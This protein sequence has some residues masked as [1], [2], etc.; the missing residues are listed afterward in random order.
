[1]AC[2]GFACSKYSLAI[3]NV[4]YLIV[5]IVLI[6]LA[7]YAKAVAI[8][9]SVPIV[10]VQYMLILFLLFLIQFAIACACLAS[11][12]SQQQTM[13]EM[14]WR[15]SS[16]DTRN[17]VQRNFQCCGFK[18][19]TKLINDPLGYPSCGGLD[20]CKDSNDA[21]C[22]KD[23]E[24]NS[25]LREKGTCPCKQTCL[26]VVGPVMSK[27]VKISGGVGLFF[28]FT[29]IIGVWLAVRFRNQKDPRANPSAFL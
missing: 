5:A 7:G 13:F 16:N 10:G 29:E 27:W 2:G 15:K 17:D 28:S 22:I 23:A 19:Q 12:T 14:G 8:V 11:N 1:M 26:N 6:S 25:T 9:S 21:C 20:C 24:T 18:D 4:L 3:L